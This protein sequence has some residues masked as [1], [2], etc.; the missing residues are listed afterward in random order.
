MVS[1]GKAN[2]KKLIQEEKWDDYLNCSASLTG[3]VGAFPERAIE[4]QDLIVPLI[5]VC[6]DKTDR[7]R[8]NSAV[9]LAKLAMN[10]DNKK[11]M[12]ANHGTE[13]LCSLQGSLI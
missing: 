4:F 1:T 2:F 7:I 8:K 10:E 12:Q 5:K 6:S 9:L 3:F 13:V 11:V